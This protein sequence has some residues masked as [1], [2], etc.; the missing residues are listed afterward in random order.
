M[1][2]IARKPAR[3]KRVIRV[4]PSDAGKRMSLSDF[5]RCDV[6]E[7]YLYELGRGVIEVSDVPSIEHARVL[8]FLRRRIEVY[9]DTR[10]GS[11][12]N[13]VGGS[14]DAKVLV[15]PLE[16]ERHPDLSVYC[17]APPAG[18]QPWG[19]WVPEVVVEVVS[20]S[21]RKRDYETKPPEYLAFGVKEYWLIDPG[22]QVVIVH[23]RVSGRFELA[24]LKPGQKLETHVL[25][26]F[27][28]DI[29]KLLLAGK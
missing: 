20:D 21:S 4:G 26:G 10:R 17:N 5:D 29:K 7:G 18:K 9:G 6:V 12:I 19:A 11:V 23:N 14:M 2:V 15:M 8:A 25:P 13:Y 1:T 16:S 27:K 28:L 3:R 24:T 22:D